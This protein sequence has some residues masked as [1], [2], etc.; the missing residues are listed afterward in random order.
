MFTCLCI[1]HRR[2]DAEDAGS[3]TVPG[4]GR[5][6]AAAGTNVPP[7][8][9]LSAFAHEYS[10]RVELVR[11]DLV[12]F[13]ASGL[14]RLFGGPRQ[15]AAHV[16]GAAAARGWTCGVALAHTR[17]AALLLAQAG[18]GQVVVPSGRE[19]QALAPLPVA[20]LAA[21]DE[22]PGAG[23]PGSVEHRSPDSRGTAHAP[24]SR[25]PTAGAGAAGSSRPRRTVAAG[26]AHH[27]RMAPLPAAPAGDPGALPMVE[28]LRRWG[29]ATIGDLAVLPRAELHGRLGEAGVRW[30]RLAHG[31]DLR[32]LVRGVVE[33]PYTQVMAL[34][35]PVEALDPLSFVLARLLDPLCARLDR[36]ERGAVGLR[37]WL[38][39]VTRT[40]CAR[41][42]QLPAPIRDAKVLRTLLLLHLESRPPEAGIDEVTL[43]LDVAP[44][45]VLQHSLLARPLPTPDHVSTLVARL[46]AL[47]GEGRCGHPVPVETLRPGTFDLAPFAPV[48]PAASAKGPRPAG[49]RQAGA[50]LSPRTADEGQ[51]HA[52]QGEPAA[53]LR[54]YRRP[55]QARVTTAGDG[56]PVRVAP[57][58]AVAPGT[59][60]RGN[61]PACGAVRA[62]AGPWRTSGEWWREPPPPGG[63]GG[64]WD[65]E[66][67]DVAL[68]DGG[69]YRISRDVVSGEWLVEGYWD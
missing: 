19:A 14:E 47:M 23:A 42:L 10:P 9:A 16:A 37:L 34:E 26:S 8:D 44:G 53:A 21:G 66:E 62:L 45:R 56:R 15:L 55:L 33:E 2:D 3:A 54:R 4:D 61:G 57:R 5:W 65:R 41:Y 13:D 32:P 51:R 39:L 24:A 38:R 22:V 40:V 30:H 50:L 46:T 48:P 58:R 12:V 18:P 64:P 49:A 28:T 52:R 63:R 25:G 17:T 36:A 27:Y 43:T 29:I 20:L 35:W 67:W 68:E 1:H 6:P 7:L 31:D 59:A 69:L 11:G 60:W